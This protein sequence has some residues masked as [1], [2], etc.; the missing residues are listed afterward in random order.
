MAERLFILDGPGF[1]FR[2]YHALPYLSTSR[3]MP[4]HAT[5]GMSTMLWKLLREEHPDYFA[6][7]W[8]PPGPDVPRAALRRVQGDAP[9]HAERPRQ[10]IPYVLA[11]FQALRLP[12]LEVSGLRGRRR[13]RHPGGPRRATCPSTSC[14][15]PATRTCSSSW[16]RACASSPPV[17]RAA[18]QVVSTRTRCR[19]SGAWR[20][21]RFPTPR[22]DGRLHR[23]HPRRP[24]RRR[25]DGGQAHQPVRQR[26]A[27]LRE[28]PPRARASCARRWP[29]TASRRSCRASSPP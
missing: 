19:S 9:G 17:G 24:R 27:A 10:Q 22:A 18:E 4:R 26:G 7:A 23:Q 13:A 25:E 15:S 29:P 11:V 1:L 5:Y 28:P 2:A 20:P 3:G 12:L 6:V 16:G 21:S 8:D 14:W